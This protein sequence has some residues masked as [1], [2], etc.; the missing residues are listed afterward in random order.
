MTDPLVELETLVPSISAAIQ[1]RRLEHT[2][3]RTVDKLA[4]LPRQA[5]R[6][7]ALVEASQVL[8]GAE[9]SSTKNLLDEAADEVDAIGKLLEEAQTPEELENIDR[10]FSSLAVALRGLDVSVR[11]LWQEKV[12]GEF[13]SLVAVGELLTRI[14]STEDLGN[15]LRSLGGDALALSERKPTAEQ[16][17]PE[18]QRL[19]ARRAAVDK[20]LHELTG[21]PE[22]DFFLTAVT[23]DV[24][25]LA[26]VTPVVMSW[27]Q[28][29]DALETFVV[30]GN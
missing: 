15:R 5:A 3:G 23:R 27:L 14:A 7:E 29:N 30:R 19:R 10:E 25:T 18:I 12:Q 4:D 20:E 9:K 13:Q 8:G 17:S 11:N 6:F 21:S 16:L 22:V 26:E 1:A 2:L 24:A 28:N